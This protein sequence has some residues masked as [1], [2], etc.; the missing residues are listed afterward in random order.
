MKAATLMAD[1]G[2]DGFLQNPCFAET[3]DRIDWTGAKFV[4]KI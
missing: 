3:L 2:S 4:R 1:S